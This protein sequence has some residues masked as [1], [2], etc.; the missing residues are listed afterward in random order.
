MEA[1][2]LETAS[3]AITHCVCGRR[4]VGEKAETEGACGNTQCIEERAARA[5][6]RA[7]MNSFQPEVVVSEKIT[8]TKC[9]KQLNRNNT[10]GVCWACRKAGEPPDPS[11]PTPA[12]R[13]KA[14]AGD[15]VKRFKVVATSLGIDPDLLLQTF[16]E[17]WLERVARSARL[18]VDDGADI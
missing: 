1:A 13:S 18:G 10:V 8:C 14:A 16:C 5:R 9:G 12:P 6:R 7:L 15:A 2:I 17:G 11:A 4:L 3:T